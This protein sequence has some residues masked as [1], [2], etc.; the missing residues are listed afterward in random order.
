MSSTNIYGGPPASPPPLNGGGPSKPPRAT[1]S[2]A[3]AS[4]F[5]GFLSLLF[6]VFAAVPAVILALVAKSDIRANPAAVRGSGLAT[7]GLIL[8]LA[9]FFAPFFWLF[10]AV[11]L[12][13]VPPSADTYDHG[14]RIAHIHLAGALLET[15]AENLSGL[16]FESAESLKQ[17]VERIQRAAEDDSVEAL[18]FTVGPLGL[19]MG[20]LEE[21]VQAIEAFKTSG[22]K[23]FAHGTALQTGSYALFSGVTHLN[24][25]PTDTVW[26]AGISL[27]EIH[28]KDALE[29]IGL[30][31]DI[32]KMGTHKSAG[33]M[34][35]RSGP[36]DAA[37]E[38]T[39]W[40]LD[41]LYESLVNIIAESRGVTNGRVI[42]MI[43]AGPYTSAR[44]L[45]A[46]LVDSVMYLD[47]FLDEIRSEYGED[48]YI[49]NYYAY[50]DATGSPSFLEEL[51]AQSAP[52]SDRGPA[53]AVV[54][55]EGTILQGYSNVSPFGSVGA[56][57]GDLV[58]LFDSAAA[59]ESVKAVVMRVDS[60]GGSAVAS[61]EILRAAVRL[62][63]KKPLI[64]S[65]GSTAASGGYYIACKADAILADEMTIT[66]SIGVIGG[67]L[68]TSEMWEELGIN[69]TS[70]SRGQNAEIF[71]GDHPFTESER[72]W[73]L[74]YMQ[75]TYD[76]FTTHVT[77]GRG[78]RLSKPIEEI[79]GG[80]VYTGKQALDL[81]LVDEIGSLMDAIKLAADRA[82][83]EDYAVRVLPE[84]VP[85][86]QQLMESLVG[87]GERPS[88]LHFDARTASPSVLSLRGLL[89]QAN[90]PLAPVAAI[91]EVIDPE[92]TRAAMDALAV[93]GILRREGV[94]AI[95]PEML[96]LH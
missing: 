73:I 76:V 60:P 79:A 91:L 51:L 14:Q 85:F 72:A 67:K 74:S 69:W 29:K 59:D 36:S 80:R 43:D 93:A 95:M 32:V 77:E 75:E 28:L 33:E 52:D 15:P 96:V 38:N 57:S 7:T 87:A 78:G 81:G 39:I 30:E 6:W 23:V 58:K 3:V 62:Q 8:G 2:A 31:A 13:S 71:S 49:D 88:D 27:T 63:E 41:G 50:D 56:F 25:V 94:A 20:Q 18:L 12:L 21:I 34:L 84:P 44:A 26:L 65:M 83:I 86:I 70:Y 35:S 48:V 66:A 40:L 5:L 64:V 61:E 1:S 46:G 55:V 24:V 16:Y 47:Q 90:P 19:G 10:L 11:G 37:R 89:Q 53:I 42:E 82:G 22:K 45:E 92:R 4:F 17:L 9:G 68:V 54:Y